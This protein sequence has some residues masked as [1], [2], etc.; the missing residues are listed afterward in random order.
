MT[1]RLQYFTE[2]E[3][4]ENNLKTSFMKMMEVYKEKKLKSLKKKNKENINTKF[5]GSQ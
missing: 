4:Q 1:A 3:T 2:V 5:G